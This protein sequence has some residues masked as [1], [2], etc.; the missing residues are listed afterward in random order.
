MRLQSRKI[1]IIQSRK[2]LI[3]LIA[4]KHRV[5]GLDLNKSSIISE[6]KIACFERME[7]QITPILRSMRT[8]QK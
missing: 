4:E 7:S 5:L 3:I 6:Q 2:M 1:L 8:V